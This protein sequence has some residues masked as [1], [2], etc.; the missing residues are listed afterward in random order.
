M[1]TAHCHLDLPG[2]GDPPTSVSLV[3]VTTGMHHHTQLMFVFFVET[4]FCHI[5]HAG[6]ELLSSGNP[7]TLA[8]QIAGITGVS[9]CVWPKNILL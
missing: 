2:S 4:R 9:Q 5:A 3:A 6:L 1:I 7:P 8:S